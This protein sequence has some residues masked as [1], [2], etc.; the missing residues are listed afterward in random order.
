MLVSKDVKVWLGYSAKSLVMFSTCSV[1]AIASAAVTFCPLITITLITLN[2]TQKAAVLTSLMVRRFVLTAILKKVIDTMELRTW[3]KDAIGE[4]VELLQNDRNSALISSAPASGKTFFACSALEM[5]RDQWN[6]ERVVVVSP[7]ENV[8]DKWQED[9]CRFGFQV[10]TGPHLP[11]DRDYHEY[12]GMS[13][14]YSYMANNTTLLRKYCEGGVLVILDEVHHCGEKNSW[15]D[16]LLESFEKADFRILLSG[17]PWRTEGTAIPFVNYDEKGVCIPDF[18]Y[19]VGQA[20]ADRVC[21]RPQ[22]HKRDIG[23]IILRKEEEIEYSCFEE[24]GGGEEE[25]ALYRASVQFESVFMEM[26]SEADQQ[27]TKV[28]KEKWSDAGGM[29]VAKDIKTAHKYAD[30]IMLKTGQDCLVVHSAMNNAH[31]KINQFKRG[32]DK[33]LIS[34]DMIGEGTD[35]PRL[36][37]MLYMHVKKAKQSLYQYWMRCARIR[38]KQS[39]TVETCHVFV[40]DHSEIA[41]VA[42]EIEGEIEVK[43]KEKKKGIWCGGGGGERTEPEMLEAIMGA[44]S[45][46]NGGFEYTQDELTAARLIHNKMPDCR[47]SLGDVCYFLKY[48]DNVPGHETKTTEEEIVPLEEKKDNLKRRIQKLVGRIALKDSQ[49]QGKRKPD[50]SNYREVWKSLNSFAGIGNSATATLIELQTMLEHA[51]ELEQSTYA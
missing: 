46:T 44:E 27:L 26:F 43:L 12:Q 33:W 20:V 47:F 18:Q 4:V 51:I 23:G 21:Q 5:M 11:Y 40:L 35:I 28:R 42:K 16:S 37:V 50:S 19:T 6:M 25:N 7:T 29:I 1:V 17:T 49:E 13:I 30:W 45:L 48:A 8:R 9:L 3:Q 41:K 24:T 10:K 38:S 22:I 34:V 14:T 15:G 39:D 31:H 36:Q 2:R 32:T